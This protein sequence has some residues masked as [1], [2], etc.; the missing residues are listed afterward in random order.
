MAEN[1][2]AVKDQMQFL[3]SISFEHE[4]GIGNSLPEIRTP[5]TKQINYAWVI[6]MFILILIR[7][8][9]SCKRCINIII[10]YYDRVFCLFFVSPDKKWI[11]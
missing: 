5:Q 7:L 4:S 6:S 2:T 10:S 8:T 11:V 9:T 1:T 3:S